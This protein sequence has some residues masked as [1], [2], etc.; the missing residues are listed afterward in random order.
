MNN[1]NQS[2]Q[3]QPIHKNNNTRK[4]KRFNSKTVFNTN[5]ELVDNL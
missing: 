2:Q 3:Q 5:N 4:V 1:I